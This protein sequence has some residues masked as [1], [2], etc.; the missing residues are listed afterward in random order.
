M[1]STEIPQAP[2]DRVRAPATDPAVDLVEHEARRVIDFRE[3]L[4]DGKG[5]ATQLTA[6]RDPRQGAGRLTRIRGDPEHDL[7]DAGAVE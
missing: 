1:P 7:V 6:R 3:D 5:D 2:P 4:L